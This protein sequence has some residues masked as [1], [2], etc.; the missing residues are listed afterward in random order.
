VADRPVAVVGGGPAGL[1]AAT[2]L[3][4]LGVGEVVVIEREAEPGG[5][6]RHARHQGFGLRDL[7]RPLSGPAYARRWAQLA[8]DAGAELRVETMVTD[9]TPGG[10]LD[11]TGPG[12][13]T[14]L[15]P[16]AVVLATGCRERPR[17]ARLVPGSRP[18]GV[19]T[20][21]M[22]QQLVYLQGMPAGKRALVVGA[23]HVSF[24]A[25]M[26][27]AH[28][29]ARAL[30]LT[31]ELPRHQSLAA[32]RLGALARYRVPLWTRTRV[33]AIHGRPR[34]EEVELTDLGTGAT[35]AVACDTV[36]FSADWIPDH[37]LAVMAGVELD[38]LTRGPAV[39]QELRTSASGVFA[40]GNMVH[41]A[42][43]ADVAAL[44]GRH[45]AAGVARYLR[46]GAWPRRR[47]L[48]M[49]EPP[50]GWIAPNAV[51]GQAAPAR[52]RFALRAS[53]FLRAPRVEVAQGE[54]VLWHGRP[55]RVMP[56]RSARLPHAW[57][58][59]VDADGPAVRVALRA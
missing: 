42:E 20:T 19:M 14:T 48:V 44:S 59:Q 5:I 52:G 16:A 12:G 13:R 40:A 55:A 6:P 54:R 18:A 3:R 47:V 46:D 22:L 38:P 32:F 8:R 27:L 50:L 11:L 7:R 26:T 28:G 43:Q 2:E 24:S 29:G 1:A 35:R 41:G 30:A 31:T 49:C 51:A 25:V 21:G 36:V 57:I 33:T 10:P 9:W 23:E 58:G 15:D 39:D 4:R 45:A 56:G 17:S 34:V 53:A 37:E